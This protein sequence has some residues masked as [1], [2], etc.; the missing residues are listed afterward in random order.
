MR[1]N[2]YTSKDSA[3]KKLSPT[4]LIEIWA[5]YQARK[6]LGTYK[7]KAK[8]YGVTPSALSEFIWNKKRKEERLRKAMKKAQMGAW[9]QMNRLPF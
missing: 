8:E 5:W 3:A 2:Q 7:S 4:A 9:E 1:Q 6:A